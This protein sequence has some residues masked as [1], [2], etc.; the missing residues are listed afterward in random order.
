[1]TP[2]VLVLI[3]MASVLRQGADG[4]FGDTPSTTLLILQTDRVM[5][6]VEELE[7][8]APVLFGTEG[9]QHISTGLAN[10]FRP[11]HLPAP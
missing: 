7:S 2:G 11:R 4:M 1:M 8:V 3:L 6:L 10:P 9:G 5:A